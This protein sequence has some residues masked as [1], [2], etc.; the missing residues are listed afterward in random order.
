[1]LSGRADVIVLRIVWGCRPPFLA[2]LARATQE[3]LPCRWP[4]CGVRCESCWQSACNALCR[5]SL[6][7]ERHDVARFLHLRSA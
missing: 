2:A 6:R 3:V 1:M 4:L 5:C 7:S